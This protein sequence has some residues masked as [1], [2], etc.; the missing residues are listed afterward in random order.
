MY[1]VPNII[2]NS[3]PNPGKYEKMVPIA[4][5]NK[6]TLSIPFTASS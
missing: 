3:F 2:Q 4:N 5:W 6:H 1:Y